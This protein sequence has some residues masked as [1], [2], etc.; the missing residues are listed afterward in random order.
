MSDQH[1]AIVGFACDPQVLGMEVYRITEWSMQQAAREL[2]DAGYV[3][4]T[5]PEDDLDALLVTPTA[6]TLEWYIEEERAVLADPDESAR[7]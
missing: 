2:A 6:E 4:L 7:A 3:T 5:R 1:I